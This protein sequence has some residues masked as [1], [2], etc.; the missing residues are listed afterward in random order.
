MTHAGQHAM[1]A[2]LKEYAAKMKRYDQEEFLMF[3][4]RDR[5]D[6][7]LDTISQKRL[8][9]LYSEYVPARFRELE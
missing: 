6:E 5:D 1:I 7:D 8:R 2:A 3:E 4:K 9:E